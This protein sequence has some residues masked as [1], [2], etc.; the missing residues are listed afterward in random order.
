MQFSDNQCSKSVV[1]IFMTRRCP[2]PHAQRHEVVKVLVDSDVVLF[3]RCHRISIQ[4]QN[5]RFGA[6]FAA[7][8]VLEIEIVLKVKL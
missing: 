8:A 5:V 1:A 6:L 3:P 7:V 2:R 4:F